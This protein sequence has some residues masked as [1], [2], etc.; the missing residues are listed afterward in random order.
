MRLFPVMRRGFLGILSVLFGLVL[1]MASGVASDF[2]DPSG[3]KCVNPRFSPLDGAHAGD[4]SPSQSPVSFV[5]VAPD[6]N[7][8]WNG[9][10]AKP[11]PGENGVVVDGPFRTIAAAQLAVRERLKEMDADH[12]GA[13]KSLVVELRGGTYCLDETLVFTPAD[14]GR[15]TD[16]PVVWKAFEDERP[17]V[18]AGRVLTGWKVGDDGR[19]TLEIPEVR[20]G[21]WYFEQLFV[22]GQRRFRPRLPKTGYYHVAAEAEP[23]DA[24]KGKGFDR[25]VWA[26]NE[27]SVNWANREDIEVCAFHEWA[28]SRMRIADLNPQTRTVTFTGRTV[29]T[30]NWSKFLTGYRYYVDNVKEALTE[31]GEW[32]LDRKTGILTY[33]PREGETPQTVDVVAPRLEQVVILQGNGEQRAWVRN[34]RFEGIAFAHTNWEL[35]PEGQ[36][37][38]QAEFG[39]SSAVAAIGARDCAFDG[40]AIVN[41]GGYAIAFG[42]GC[43]RNVVENTDMLD[44]AAGGVMIGRAMAGTWAESLNG[45]SDEEAV[46]SHIT[47][48]NCTIRG[49]GRLHPAAVGIWIGHSPDNTIVQNDICDLYYTA[50]SVGWVWGY[51]NSLAKRNEIG[52]NHMYHLGQRILS[53]MGGVYTLG[54]SEGTRV[55]DNVIHDVDA[56]SYGGWGLYTDEGST[57]I[58]MDNNLVYR[59]KTGGFHQHYGKE[60]HIENNIF[61]DAQVQQL[62]RTR[63]EEH[64]SFWFERNI[65]AWSNDSPLMGSNWNDNHFQTDYNVY[66]HNGE[67]VKFFGDKT[68]EEWR[69]ERGQDEHSVIADPKFVDPSN[70]DYRVSDR[71][72]AIPLGFKPFDPSDAGRKTTSRWT[73]FFA[74]P[75]S[76]FVAE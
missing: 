70:D 14:S 7:D 58:T 28:M 48:R 72:P 49:A 21:T 76:G 1:T 18:S 74:M 6:G 47:V 12:D 2:D 17:I 64:L 57:G 69:K 25:F 46:V 51:G 61:V 60:N 63:T 23:S 59:T 33:I 9:S 68:L 53:D 42:A 8:A 19:W 39:L 5:Y 52:Y 73:D 43:K 36:V 30:S 67:D 31:P 38:P 27:L 55:H 35:A 32:Y 50:V 40:C 24:A 22:N 45:A 41:T 75:P 37:F 13:A 71:S 15:T 65:A 20:A 11:Q 10:A 3:W 29:S 66:W 54:L 34:L 44:L 62:Q 56:F 4:A 16:A 26:E